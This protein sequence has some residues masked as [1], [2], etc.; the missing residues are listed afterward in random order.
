MTSDKTE[1]LRDLIREAAYEAN[2]PPQLSSPARGDFKFRQ[3]YFMD[4][5]LATL[6]DSDGIHILNEMV[7]P[8]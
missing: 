2:M 6:R 1:V 8:E 4:N 7:N 3:T 5:L